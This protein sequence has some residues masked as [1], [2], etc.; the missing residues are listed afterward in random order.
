MYTVAEL[1]PGHVSRKRFYYSLNWN[2]NNLKEL[3]VP[4]VIYPMR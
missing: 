1:E 4:V 2:L 3:L